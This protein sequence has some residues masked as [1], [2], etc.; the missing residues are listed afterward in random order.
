MQ[1]LNE[2]LSSPVAL[3]TYKGSKA[4]KDMIAEMIKAKYGEVELKNYDPFRS[5]MTYA[6]WM[7]IG[8]RP[9]RGEQAMKSTTFV[10]IKDTGG[11]VIKKQRRSVALF[12][13]RQVEQ[14]K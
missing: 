4:T 7:K 3:S 14:L 10:E 2:I 13:Y 6:S 1:T 11:K 12:Y 5:M 8:F 9:R